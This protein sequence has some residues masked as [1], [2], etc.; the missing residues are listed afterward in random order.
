MQVFLIA[1]NKVLKINSMSVSD[2]AVELFF[3]NGST[4]EILG[5]SASMSTSSVYINIKQK[6]LFAFSL[7]G[8]LR[9]TAAPMLN[10]F[11]Y[12]QGCKNNDSDCYFTS[13]PVIDY[14]E[15]S[16]YVSAPYISHVDHIVLSD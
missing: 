16:V 10:Q 12:F 14:C 5:L 3:G 13:S 7:R 6:G 1:E 15:S 2:P 4:D 8:R 9:W 11:G